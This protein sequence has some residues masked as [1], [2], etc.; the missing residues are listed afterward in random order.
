MLSKLVIVTPVFN[1]WGAFRQLLA[2]LDAAAPQWNVAVDI[3]AVD[4]GSFEPP[5]LDH[6]VSCLKNIQA[7]SIVSLAANIGH[8]RAIAVGLVHVYRLMHYDQCVVMDCDGEDRPEDLAALLGLS[9]TKPGAVVTA[10]RAQ[11]FENWRLRMFYKIYKKLFS[12]LT[13]RQIDFGNFCLIPKTQLARIVHMAE[14]WNHL[15]GTLIRSRAPLTS[16]STVKGRRYQGQSTMNF[17]SLVVHGLSAIAVFSD[18][19]FVRLLIFS[20]ALLL[21]PLALAI[22]VVLLRLSTN[23]AIPGWTTMV[24]GFAVMYILQLLTS[25]VPSVVSSLSNRS[26]VPFVPA[27]EAVAFVREVICLRKPGPKAEATLT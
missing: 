5:M 20:L 2:A 15:A 23:L 14:L 17:V 16:V 24:F 13:G 27:V 1:D 19:L 6:A 7:V 8:Q 18:V 11:R 22:G 12:L 10:K 26:N 21:L 3:V 4:D 25:V 9:A